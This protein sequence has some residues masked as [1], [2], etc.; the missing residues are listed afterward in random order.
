MAEQ[1]PSFP[2]VI[3]GGALIPHMSARHRTQLVDAL[4]EAVG[5]FERAKAHIEASEDNY[6]DF[7]MAW[8]K[9]Q[10]KAINTEHTASDDLSNLIKRLDQ[11][12]RMSNATVID[13]TVTEI[14]DA[15]EEVAE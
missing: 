8:M 11:E 2:S 9:G 7:F 1:L 14:T 12:D 15:V 10:A 3:P 13:G 6:H 4:F 5:G